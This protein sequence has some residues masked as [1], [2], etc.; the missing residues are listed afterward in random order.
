[1][2]AGC[3]KPLADAPPAR[4]QEPVPAAA[5][6][7]VRPL[8]EPPAEELAPLPADHLLPTA[9]GVV[10]IEV[11][12]MRSFDVRSLARAFVLSLIDV[13]LEAMER[14]C[15]FVPVVVVERLVISGS[16]P[17]DRVLAAID[18]SEV[19]ASQVLECLAKIHPEARARELMGRPVLE[20]GHRRLWATERD[21]VLLLA[22]RESLAEALGATPLAPTSP[23]DEDVPA[24]ERSLGDVKDALVL[25]SRDPHRLIA[26]GHRGGGAG[27][28]RLP[29]L[30]ITF[31][32]DGETIAVAGDVD[33]SDEPQP[34]DLDRIKRK[35]RREI[36]D[37]M[38]RIGQGVEEAAPLL[39]AVDEARLE[40]RGGHLIFSG[41]TIALEALQ[42][43]VDGV[44]TKE[45]ERELE[46]RA[47]EETVV[48]RA[49]PAA[50]AEPSD[51]SRG[52]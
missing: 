46:H 7:G 2:L 24:L 9:D 23:M 35:L 8:D 44:A 33:L 6:N 21:G 17:N 39:R 4:P 43:L 50:P 52:R 41:G 42:R 1:M 20:L 32:F 16:L 29:T 12:R 31:T 30:T 40:Q 51:V 13:D 38:D 26:V 14:A 49:V 34:E 3:A 37:E 10:V 19:S 25:L 45:I 27:F 5:P 47:A 22:E 15:G 48:E 28:L 18:L 11:A 36:A